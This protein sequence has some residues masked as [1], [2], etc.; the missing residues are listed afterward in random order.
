MIRL[1][2]AALV[3][4]DLELTTG[5]LADEYGLTVCFNDPGVATFGL[6]NALMTVGDQFLE[7]VAPVRPDTTAGRLLDKRATDVAGYMAIYEVDDLDA[8]ETALGEA[9]IRIVWKGDLPDIRGRHLHPVDVGGAIV[10]IDQPVPQGAW[11]WAGPTWR[12][13]RDTS[14]VTAIAGVVVAAKD[15]AAMRA[16]WSSLGLAHSVR[17][18][19]ATHGEGLDELEL[20]ATDRSRAGEER[21]LGLLTIRLV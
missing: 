21:R 11:R 14:V 9:G 17:F 5:F 13:H 12:A 10:S 6:H 19:E 18:V 4:R 1:R 7:V 3:A 8:R 16:R 15:P 20:V 2:Q